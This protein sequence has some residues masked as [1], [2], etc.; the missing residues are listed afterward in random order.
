MS[1][2]RPAHPGVPR[3][4]TDSS[5]RPQTQRAGASAP[6]VNSPSGL[7]SRPGGFGGLS[8]ASTRHA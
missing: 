5:A 1:G 8:A 4:R 2:F 7:S 3:R 6:A